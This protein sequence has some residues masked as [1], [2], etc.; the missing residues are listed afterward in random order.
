ML[1]SI[2]LR[3]FILVEALEVTFR[4][5]LT[6]LTGETGAGKSL[7]VDALSLALGARGESGLIRQGAERAEI[8]AEFDIS[9]QPECMRWLEQ[10]ELSAEPG[11]CLLRR[12]FDGNGRSRAYIN[13]S[14]VTLS[15]LKQIGDLLVDI[16]GQHAHHALLRSEVQRNLLDGFAGAESTAEQVAEA[17][18]AWKTARARLEEAH[19]RARERALERDDIQ[20]ALSDLLPVRDDISG[21]EELQ[22][23]HARLSHAAALVEGCAQ[24]QAMLDE[25]ENPVISQLAALERKIGE[26]AGYDPALQPVVGLIEDSQTQLGEALHEI[27]RY[28]AKL[29]TGSESLADLDS[30]MGEVHRL[31][32]KYHLQPDRLLNWITEMQ[33]RLDAL[34]KA[35]NVEALRRME[36]TAASRY[37]EQAVQLGRLRKQAGKDLVRTVNVALSELALADARFEVRLL[38]LE[39]PR[40]CGMEEVAFQVSTH[41]GLPAGPLEKIASGGELSRISLAVQTAISGQAGVPTLILDEVDVGIGGAVAEAVGRRLAQLG[42]TKQ[43][44]VITHL[45]QVAAWGDHHLLVNK[46]VADGQPISHIR[47]LDSRGRVEEIARMLGGQEITTTSRKHAEE[48]LEFSVAR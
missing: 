33:H 18:H 23:S 45:P 3:D 25:G 38:P 47:T 42:K 2:S 48:M 29:N 9:K 8:S 6:V 14:A 1:N 27:R 24:V 35:E 31:S 16:H 40:A 44:L 46:G 15:Q 36:E 17:W 28:A 10:A 22:A 11:E 37:R 13:G 32:R 34:D 20:A 43:V 39:E 30:R 41:P 26:L 4:E 21:W 5:G 12:V 7:L 19:T